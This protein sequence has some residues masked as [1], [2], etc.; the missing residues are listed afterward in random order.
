MLALWLEKIIFTRNRERNN[1]REKIGKNEI[2]KQASF[3]VFFIWKKK[4]RNGYWVDDVD[5]MRIFF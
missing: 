3:F 1:N 4:R 5:S 2:F